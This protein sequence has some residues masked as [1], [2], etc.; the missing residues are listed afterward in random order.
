MALEAAAPIQL[1]P[2]ILVQHRFRPQRAAHTLKMIAVVA[3]ITIADA[4]YHEF[5]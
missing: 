1:A 2:G 4:H 3:I 5:A